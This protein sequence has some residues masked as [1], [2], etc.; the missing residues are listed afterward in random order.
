MTS[1]LRVVVT[2]GGP[3][4]V[5]AARAPVGGILP[6]EL[7]AAGAPARFREGHERLPAAPPLH[8]PTTDG[9]F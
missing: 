9:G 8:P 7:G 1:A 2:G 4:D 5:S 6:G 3:L